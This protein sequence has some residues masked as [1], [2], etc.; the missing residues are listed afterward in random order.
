MREGTI[1]SKSDYI[2]ITELNS[3]RLHSEGEDI[4]KCKMCVCVQ[5][6]TLCDRQSK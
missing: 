3:K 1:F 6:C 5:L 4:S 2:I